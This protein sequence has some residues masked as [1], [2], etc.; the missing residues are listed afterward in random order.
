MPK[1]L[2][3]G[4]GNLLLGDDGIGP[5][6]VQNLSQ[7]ICRSDVD[8][9]D[10]GTGGLYLLGYLEGY[11]HLLVIDALDAG[12][13][14][15][16]ICRLSPEEIGYGNIKLSFHQTGLGDLLALAKLTGLLPQTVI[17]GIQIE[18]LDW[19]M[20]LSPSVAAQLPL[21][22]ELV[23]QEIED[24]CNGGKQGDPYRKEK[25]EGMVRRCTSL[26]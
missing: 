11:S 4:I 24:I 14:P 10:G 17:F 9:L 20:N 15:G 8:F 5:R 18:R 12:L 21:L 22:E 25:A 23:L 7:R 6:V 1:I 26:V 19:G 2:V 16:T 13:R 3:L